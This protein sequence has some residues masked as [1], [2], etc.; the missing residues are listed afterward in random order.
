VTVTW[1]WKCLAPTG[2]GWRLFT[3]LDDANGPRTN[4]DNVGDTRRA[5]QPE[6]WRAGEF[7]RDT[8]TF[9]LPADWDSP[10]VRVHL[11]LWKDGAPHGPHRRAGHRRRPPRAVLELNTGVQVQVTRDRR[12]PRDGRHHRRRRL[13]EPRGPTPRARARWSTP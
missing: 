3:H 10:V 8:Q 6:R 12:A 7:I 1:Y 4:Q 9:E 11:G 13:D 5:Y 2:E